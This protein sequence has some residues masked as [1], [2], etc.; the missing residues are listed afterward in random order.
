MPF[1]QTFR[2]QYRDADAD[3]LIGLRGCM[4]YFQDIHTWFMHSIGKGNDVLPEQYGAAWVYTR[5][6]VSLRR[7]LD[8]TD[9]VLATAW[10]EPYRQPVLLNIDCV[11]RQHGEIVA[12]GKLEKCLFSLTRQRPLR[13][14]A[15]DFP[16]GI[17][18]ESEAANAIPD[19]IRLEKTAEGMAER[20]RRAVRVSDLDKSRH[21]TNLRYIDMYLD[22]YDAAF[23]RAFDP[24][25]MEITFLSQCREGEELTVLSREEEAAVRLAAVHGDGSLASVALFGK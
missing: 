15:I 21:M 22:A 20:Y 2:P 13:L 7:K 4:H 9:T 8:Y 25:E 16:E 3:G 17:P 19:F 23:W 10:M 6:H 24:R 1:E 5:Y 18:E 14:S 11:L 12:T